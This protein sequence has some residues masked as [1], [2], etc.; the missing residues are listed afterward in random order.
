[1]STLVLLH[2][3]EHW[4]DEGSIHVRNHPHESHIH[5]LEAIGASSGWV[6]CGVHNSVYVYVLLFF[7]PRLCNKASPNIGMH[8]I[9]QIALCSSVICLK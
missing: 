7:L 5:Y 4:Q 6:K 8:N 1:M 2:D 3:E 9:L